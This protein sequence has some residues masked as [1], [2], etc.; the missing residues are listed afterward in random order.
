MKAGTYNG[1]GSGKC[2]RAIAEEELFCSNS[3]GD[4]SERHFA[5]EDPHI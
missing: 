3:S 1:S 2:E 4:A 5:S